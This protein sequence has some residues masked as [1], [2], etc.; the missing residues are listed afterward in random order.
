MVIF[1]ECLSRLGDIQ[2]FEARETAN[3]SRAVAW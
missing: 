3:N 1:E 2:A